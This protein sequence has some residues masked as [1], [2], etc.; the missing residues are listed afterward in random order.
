M[1]TEQVLFSTA[2][3][4]LYRQALK[5]RLSEVLKLRLRHA[6]LDLNR[7]LLPAYPRKVWVRSLELTAEEL[8]PGLA[9]EEAMAHL[10]EAFIQGYSNTLV[11]SAVMS[12]SRLLGPGRTLARLTRSLRT[13]NNYSE[14]RL[15]AH[16]PN[17][18]ALWVN[19]PEDTEGFME[20]VLQAGL[21][22]AGAREPLVQR[23]RAGPAACEYTL[24]W[25]LAEAA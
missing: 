25:A 17:R 15:T 19:E 6:G 5:G 1:T 21:R 14:A 24:S 12:M 10:G 7:P 3:E 18:Y 8:Y 23:V 20:G 9:R 22:M 2:V 4:S 11:G 13:A 16:A